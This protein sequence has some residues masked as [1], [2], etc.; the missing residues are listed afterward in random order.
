VDDAAQGVTRVVR[1][2]DLLDSTS[3]QR[4]LQRVLGLPE[5]AYAHVPLVLGGDGARLAK[6]HGSVTLADLAVAGHDAR[7]VLALLGASLGWCQRDDAR[8]IPDLLAG[9]VADFRFADLPR[10]PWVLPSSL[11]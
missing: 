6:R 8:S 10:E 2:D 3:R 1:G 11:V 9:F 7:G 5:P 4:W